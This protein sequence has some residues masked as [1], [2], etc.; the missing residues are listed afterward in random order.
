MAAEGSLS[1]TQNQGQ[2]AVKS[3]QAA[4]SDLLA[5][6]VNPLQGTDSTSLFSRGNTLPI[7]AVPFAM[8]HWALQSSNRNAWLFSAARSAIEG[9]PLHAP[10]ERVA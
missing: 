7:V 2:A 3:R 6:L 1:G 10:I 9:H 5:D 4:G 8:A